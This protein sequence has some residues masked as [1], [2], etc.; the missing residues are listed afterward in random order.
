MYKFSNARNFYGYGNFMSGIYISES[1]VKLP[2]LA[3]LL[4]K[5]E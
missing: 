5:I 1:E 2:A 4:L 3:K